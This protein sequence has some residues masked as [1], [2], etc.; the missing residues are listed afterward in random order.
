[1]VTVLHDCIF[2]HLV[3]IVAL[4]SQ[5]LVTKMIIQKERLLKKKML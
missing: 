1:M 5:Q 4:L 2:V 3:L